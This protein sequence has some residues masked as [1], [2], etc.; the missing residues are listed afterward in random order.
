[1]GRPKNQDLRR[2]QLLQAARAAIV[3]HGI[4]E[5]GVRDIAKAAGM[6]PGSITYYYP[7]LD[8]LLQQVQNDAADRFVTQRWELVRR[9]EGPTERLVGLVEHGV[10]TG[11]DD[12]L[13]C[14]LNEFTGLA[15]RNPTYR[16]L[17]KTLYERQVAIYESVLATGQT[18]G[19]FQ[20]AG[21][22]LPIARNLVGLEDV[23]A[24]HV[25]SQASFT[26]EQAIELILDYARVAVGCEV[27]RTQSTI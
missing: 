17:W 3:E 9:V 21:P 27:S 11:P 15:R 25:V 10:A 22:V 13:L 26:R 2:Q 16:L 6:S 14:L 19:A 20:L 24:F 1:M 18:L 4:G 7:A 8:D 5:V 23:Y 12:E